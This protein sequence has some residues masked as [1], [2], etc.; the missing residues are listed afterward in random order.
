MQFPIES[1]E[2]LIRVLRENPEL[3]EQV[4]E[5]L[6]TEE[7]RRLPTQMQELWRAIQDLTHTVQELASV[8]QELVST[9]RGL[10]ESHQQAI[11]RLDRLEE[12]HRDAIVRLDRL[13]ASVRA[14]QQAT[15]QRFEE[16]ERRLSNLEQALES[17]IRS[18]E[19]RFEEVERRLSN[20]ESVLEA[21]MRSTEQRFQQIEKRLDRVERDTGELK[22][23]TL[24]LR[25]YSRAPALFGYY[26]RKPKVVD[27]G[28][29][30]DKL[31]DQGHTF[32]RD[33]WVKLSEIDV[34]LSARHPETGETLYLAVEVSWELY[35]DDVERAIERAEILRERGVNV[36]PALAGREITHEAQRSVVR[37]GILTLVDG[38]LISPGSFA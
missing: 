32:S 33:E 30:L 8:V 25:Y 21:F 6:F 29:F 18:T 9:V 37:Q 2:D 4:R 1:I 12:S 7:E 24:E 10:S 11:A 28:Q 35:P 23:Y 27:L 22:G 14:F 38:T 13:E 15:E 34:F 31:R 3:R 26:V 20:L 17:F 16:V 19:Q 5:V 36:Y